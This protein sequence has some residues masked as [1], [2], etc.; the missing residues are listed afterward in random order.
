MY[1]IL[2]LCLYIKPQNLISISAALNFY[3]DGCL[4]SFAAYII[5]HYLLYLYCVY[6]YIWHRC[7][8]KKGMRTRHA[9]RRI[10]MVKISASRPEPLHRSSLLQ[11]KREVV[12]LFCLSARW[13]NSSDWLNGNI[14]TEQNLR[15][16]TP[17]KNCTRNEN[18][19]LSGL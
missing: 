7:L 14:K 18:I 13:C 3:C 8:E 6:I 1:R 5:M 10:V 16:L 19:Y 15:K 9:G 11:I 17:A 2:L 4:S 12:G